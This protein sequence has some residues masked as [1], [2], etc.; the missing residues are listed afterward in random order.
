MNR[1]SAHSASLRVE[2]SAGRVRC[3]SPPKPNS[4]SSRGPHQG[5]SIVSMVGSSVLVGD[6]GGAVFVDQVAGLEAVQPEGGVQRVR[7]APRQRMGE[8]E[9]GAGCRLEAAGSPA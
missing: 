5:Q 3:A 9:A 2:G 8:D 4:V 6:G 7:L 1:N